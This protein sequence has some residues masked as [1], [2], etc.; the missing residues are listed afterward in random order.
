[1]SHADDRFDQGGVPFA[2]F[3]IGNERTVYL[4]MG[5]RAVFQVFERGVAGAEVVESDIHSHLFDL[6]KYI[7]RIFNIFHHR[8]FGD[9]DDQTVR[10]QVVFLHD[11]PDPAHQVFLMELLDGKIDGDVAPGKAHVEPGPDLPAGGR[12][13]PLADFADQS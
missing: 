7:H 12:Q 6:V 4:D 13:H 10:G 9:L 11:C 2:R 8:A 5:D 3:D 1:M